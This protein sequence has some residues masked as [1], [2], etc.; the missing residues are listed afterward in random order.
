M[1]DLIQFSSVGEFLNMGGYAVNVWLVYALFAMFF[2][3]NL[4]YPLIRKRQI[5]LEQKRRL[6]LNKE[7]VPQNEDNNEVENLTFRVGGGT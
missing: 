3:V 1:F 2:S 5:V 7:I 4:T 6:I